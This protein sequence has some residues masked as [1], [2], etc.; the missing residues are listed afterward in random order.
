MKKFIAFIIILCMMVP[1]VVRAE[2]FDPFAG[3][4]NVTLSMLGGSLTSGDGSYYSTRGWANKL[5]E[6]YYPQTYSNKI[7]TLKK[8]G[9]GGTGSQYGLLRFAVDVGTQ[10]PDIVF[11]EFGV[12][13]RGYPQ[14]NRSDEAKRNMESIIRQC[15]SLPSKPYVAIIGLTVYDFKTEILKLHKEVADY[16]NIPMLDLSDY[17]KTECDKQ[18]GA[19]Y[20]EK[21]IAAFGGSDGVHPNDGGY[22]KWYDEIVRQ[23]DELGS[24][25]YR[26]PE[27][28]AAIYNNE[29]EVKGLSN[30]VANKINELPMPENWEIGE[31]YKGQTGVNV[32]TYTTDVVGAVMNFKFHGNSIAL[33]AQRG[34]GL[35]K[36]KLTIDKGTD[37]ETSKT[38]TQ[39]FQEKLGYGSK[40]SYVALADSG[41]SGIRRKLK[42][43]K[44]I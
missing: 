16:Y 33:L 7:Y 42:I 3:K 20:K 8:A 22:Q 29:T 2:S 11:I 32:T 19:D 14:E 1:C 12:N 39:F 44:T 4:D 31:E 17:I 40:T 38:F 6:E 24:D 25:F 23:M 30:I 15:M 41:M 28:K 26:R 9:V 35:G 5:Y 18:E 10:N 27:D 36:F 34:S 43:L 37:Y 13:D 21:F